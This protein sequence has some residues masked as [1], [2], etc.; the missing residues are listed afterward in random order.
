MFESAWRHSKPVRG[1]FLSPLPALSA[2]ESATLWFDFFF[3]HPNGFGGNEVNDQNSKSQG[4]V[5]NEGFI[6]KAL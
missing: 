1:N 3:L 2:E 5:L 4:H 6:S